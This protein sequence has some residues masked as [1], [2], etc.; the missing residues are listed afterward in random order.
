MA[1][2]PDAGDLGA[3]RIP[4]TAGGIVSNRAGEIIGAAIADTGETIQRFQDR[5]ADARDRLEIAQAKADVLK[6][7]SEFT[8]IAERDADYATIPKRYSDHM[9]KAREAAAAKI[10][11]DSS[12]ELFMVD[13]DVTISRGLESMRSMSRRKEVAEGRRQTSVDAENL[14]DGALRSEDPRVRGEFLTALNARIDSVSDGDDET[15]GLGYLTNAE[16]ADLKREYGGRYA[17]GWL[18]GMDLRGQVAALEDVTGKPTAYLPEPERA[19]QLRIAKDRLAAEEE[20]QRKEAEM[21]ARLRRSEARDALMDARADSLAAA[22]AGLPT[23]RMP[24][25]SLY[26]A[27]YGGDEGPTRYEQDSKLF[28]VFETVATAVTLPTAEGLA[29]VGRYKV[30]QQEG[31]AVDSKIHDVAMRQYV[32]QRK[33][34]EADPAGSILARD[35]ALESLYAAAMD[36]NTGAAEQYAQKVTAKAAAMG[37]EPRILPEA[38]AESL[39]AA[40]RFDPENPRRRVD[41]IKS[42]KEAWGNRRFPQ[43]L[44]EVAP[45]LEGDARLLV[46]MT[47]QD[48][49]TYD[50][51]LAAGPENVKKAVPKDKAKTIGDSVESE[52]TDLTDTMASEVDAAGQIAQY[53][54]AAETLAFSLAATNNM[55][56]KDAAAAAVNMLYRKKYNFRDTLRVPKVETA[57]GRLRAIDPDAVVRGAEAVRASISAD[58]L[59]VKTSVYGDADLDRATLL[60]D[61]RRDGKWF[62]T[63]GEAGAELRIMRAGRY[64]PV[65]SKDGQPIRRTWEQLESVAPPPDVRPTA[66]PRKNDTPWWME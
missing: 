44:R 23:A 18:S 43:I 16:A 52:I 25:R 32:T 36:G 15:P 33:A 65:A 45:K 7:D 66:K 49:L 40:M 62:A 57:G 34:M 19:Q 21:E 53:K 63:P 26:V 60:E 56:G 42:W 30:T 8:S 38:Q 20:R 14:L 6:A 17:R 13:T 41:T 11:R 10:G 5:R 51:A 31:A 24:D 46:D 3:R 61:V 9:A 29:M 22:E 4:R 47:E 64:V 39:A 27:A 1:R 35:R 50:A 37:I 12:R 59:L 55:S 48:A 2:I 28:G 54:E 58:D